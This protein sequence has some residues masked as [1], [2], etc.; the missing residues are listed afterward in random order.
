MHSCLQAIIEINIRKQYFFYPKEILNTHTFPPFLSID[1]SQK[2]AI[3]GGAIRAVLGAI[4][5]H[6]DN[7]DICKL[8]CNIID[9]ICIDSKQ[10]NNLLYL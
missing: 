6:A 4:N 10:Y 5:M 3:N 2:R 8:G 7:D 1:I 9:S